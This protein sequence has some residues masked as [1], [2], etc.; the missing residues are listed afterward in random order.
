[1]NSTTHGEVVNDD[2]RM[3]DWI[4]DGD[5]KLRPRTFTAADAVSLTT[6]TDLFARKFDTEIDAE[7]LD[8][9][10]AHLRTQDVANID[11]APALGKLLTA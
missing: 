6:S 4:P 9:L 1:M 7:I 11:Q 10:E 3:I 2:K 8:I 5:I